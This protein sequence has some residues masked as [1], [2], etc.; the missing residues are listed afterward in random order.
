L[1]PASIAVC[2]DA[3][4]LVNKGVFKNISVVLVVLVVSIDEI[5][6]KDAQS[7]SSLSWVIATLLII[8]S[9]DTRFEHCLYRADISLTSGISSKGALIIP[10]NSKTAL[11]NIAESNRPNETFI[12]F[13]VPCKADDAVSTF[14]TSGIVKSVIRDA[15]LH[16]PDISL[17]FCVFIAANL[18]RK[19]ALV[20]ELKNVVTLLASKKL[21]SSTVVVNEKEHVVILGFPVT[22]IILVPEFDTLIVCGLDDRIVT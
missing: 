3:F 17:T 13:D 18:S 16:I 5:Q 7:S 15:L 14:D 10:D 9:T 4:G 1:L 2:S 22:V 6:I 12:K 8:S 11:K 21:S 19:K 20:H